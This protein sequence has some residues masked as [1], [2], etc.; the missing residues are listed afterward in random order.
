V[1][2]RDRATSRRADGPH[3]AKA[4]RG[5]AQRHEVQRN[6]AMPRGAERPRD[7]TSC[8]RTARRYVL[9][10]DRGLHVVQRDRSTPRV[11]EKSRDATWCRDRATSRCAEGQRDATA[12]RRKSCKLK[13]FCDRDVDRSTTGRFGPALGRTVRALP[14]PPDTRRRRTDS[15]YAECFQKTRWRG[16]GCRLSGAIGKRYKLFCMG[17]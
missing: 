5:T 8:R 7:V 13:S 10:R 16:S 11:A 15:E 12:C 17:N 3:A 4:R 1:V 9:L 14:I 2:Q 6:R